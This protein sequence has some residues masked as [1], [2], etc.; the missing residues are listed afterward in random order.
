MSK[1]KKEKETRERKRSLPIAPVFK[2]KSESKPVL[3]GKQIRM[4]NDIF[5]KKKGGKS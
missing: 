2:S 3:R 1:K 4:I 5:L